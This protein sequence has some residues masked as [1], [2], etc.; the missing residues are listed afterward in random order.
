MTDVKAQQPSRTAMAATKGTVVVVFHVNIAFNNGR[1]FYW[2]QILFFFKKKLS[3]KFLAH[4]SAVDFPT[5]FGPQRVGLIQIRPV[6]WFF[7]R[8]DNVTTQ[9]NC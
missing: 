8:V 6:K 1:G 9:L 5:L 7:F 4:V 3:F 2:S